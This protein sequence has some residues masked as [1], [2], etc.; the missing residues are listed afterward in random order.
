MT[1]SATDVAGNTG[2]ASFTVEVQDVKKPIVT[3]PSDFFVEATGVSGATV[4]YNGVS[5]VDDVDGPVGVTCGPASGTVFP[6]GT[7]TVTCTASDTAGNTGEN[8]FEVM[9]RDTTAPTVTAP[10][11]Q[12]AEATSGAGAVV[13]F[14]TSAS[15]VVD[16][17]VSTTC[18]PASGSTFA[19]GSVEVVC[20]ATDAAGNTGYASSRSPSRTRPHRWSRSR[21]M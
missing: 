17:E 21:P 7:T 18:V 16:G 9:V 5:A 6:L 15:D 13:T 12:E 20:S 8:S 11:A 19:L 10:G 3:V 1:C 4:S 2:T 14:D